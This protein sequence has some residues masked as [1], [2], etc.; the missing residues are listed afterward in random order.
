M[1][2]QVWEIFPTVPMA[3]PVCFPPA[4]ELYPVPPFPPP[5]GAEAE[6]AAAIM[7]D[8]SV[9]AVQ[10]L[11]SVVRVFFVLLFLEAGF[12]WTVSFF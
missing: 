7:A 10:G 11:L 3:L 4:A 2:F 6:A 9:I 8:L 1:C 5:F 12:S